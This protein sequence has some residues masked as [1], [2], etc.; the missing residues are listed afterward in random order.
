MWEVSRFDG[1]RETIGERLAQ[2][3]PAEDKAQA[4][5]AFRRQPPVRFEAVAVSVC[6]Q[7]F[8]QRNVPRQGSISFQPRHCVSCR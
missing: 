8:E 1:A 7:R 6:T 2:G 5:F 3:H 4:Q